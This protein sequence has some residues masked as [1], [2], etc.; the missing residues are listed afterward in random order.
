[1]LEREGEPTGLI[2]AFDGAEALW[3]LD[4]VSS[5]APAGTLHRLE[6]GERGLPA[7]LF[8]VSSHHLGLADA[9]ELARAV[10]RLPAR[11]VVYGIEGA[12]F[13]VGDSLTPEVEA[14]AAQA[15]DAVRAEVRAC[16]GFG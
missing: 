3:L 8:R 4:A 13:G 6:A 2:D 10:G 16:R 15:A 5:G 7:A 14:A 11:V 1:M 9:I 12:Q